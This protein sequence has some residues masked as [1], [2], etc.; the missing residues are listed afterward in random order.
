MWPLVDGADGSTLRVCVV[1]KNDGK[2]WT[3]INV[4][5]PAG[6][7]QATLVRMGPGSEGMGTLSAIT[8]DT[9]DR[10]CST[11][12]RPVSKARPATG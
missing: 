9:V 5:V 1:N 6:Y 11:S 4:K 7:G 8:A 2:A 3:I 12:V 10:H